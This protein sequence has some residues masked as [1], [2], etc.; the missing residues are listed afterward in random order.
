MTSPPATS[1]ITIGVDRHKDAHVAAAVDQLGRILATTSIPTTPHGFVQLQC[2]AERLGQVD[3]FGVEG[4]GSFAAGLT[5]WL[6]QRGYQVVEVTR[7]NRQLRRR[8]G[9]SDPVDAES[10]ARAALGGEATTPKAANDTVEMLRVL[11]VA[12]RSAITARGQ[13]ANQLHS[14]LVTA[15]D[16]LR[17]QLRGLPLA[18]LVQVAAAFRPGPLTDPLTA[19]KLALRELARRYQLLTVELDRLDAQLATLVPKAAP[20][21]LT[22][23]GVGAQVAGALLVVA[24]D[25]PG[26]LR[27]EAA[28]S[29][30]CGSSPLEAS[31]GKTV[32][33]RL[34]RG[35]DR[36]ANNALW[37][38]AM[39]LSC[40]ER[41]Q[42]YLARRTAEGKS[43]REIIRCLKRYIAREVYRDIKAAIVT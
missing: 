16:Q 22:R 2:W 29:M 23:R 33:H 27:S 8:R 13:A 40:D 9:K 38:I 32:R 39:V 18:R 5:R 41:T 14:L 11:R 31:S 34:N 25:N 37:T 10:A 4:T 20:R 21:L 28:F 24:G 3:R 30:L 12:R 43:K 36:D 35:G 19:T 6:Q 1:V 17:H 7:P 42:R 15:P 26:R